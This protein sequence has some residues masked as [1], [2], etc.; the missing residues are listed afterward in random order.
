MQYTLKSLTMAVLTL[1]TS[2][3]LLASPVV[4]AHQQHN[5]NPFSFGN[6][7]KTSNKV[8][9]RAVAPGQVRP[10]TTPQHAFTQ[11]QQA[12]ATM[13][14]VQG[15]VSHSSSGVV[16][17][18]TRGISAED[19]GRR[20]IHHLLASNGL[21]MNMVKSFELQQEDVLNAAT[22]GQNIIFTE[23]LWHT[24]TTDDQRAFVLS[25]EIAHITLNHIPKTMGRRVGFGLFG[26]VLSDLVGSRAG[27]VTGA[28]TDRVV[29]TG[30]GL[31]ELKFSRKA[32]YAADERG[33]VFLRN[34]GYSTRASVE[35][36]EVLQ[37][38]GGGGGLEFLR[39]HPLEANRIDRLASQIY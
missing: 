24:L 35:T 6:V 7:F 38:Q 3:F 19:A 36:M 21:P 33:L 23:K 15:Q 13:Q 26:R 10:I 27:G 17:P 1:A 18:Q 9:P 8:T 11:Q 4:L 28:I 30:L 31:Y 32:E 12:Y 16:P 29:S 37:A 14:P 39:S 34:A 2:G 5:A 22:D 20:M 25:H